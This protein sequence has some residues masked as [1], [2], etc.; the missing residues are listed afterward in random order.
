MRE[1]RCYFETLLYAQVLKDKTNCGKRL[2]CL[3]MAFPKGNQSR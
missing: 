2:A 3:L 1:K